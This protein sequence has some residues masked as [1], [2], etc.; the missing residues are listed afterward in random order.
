MRQLEKFK[1]RLAALDDPMEAALYIDE[2]READ[3]GK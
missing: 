1:E 3:S 2:M